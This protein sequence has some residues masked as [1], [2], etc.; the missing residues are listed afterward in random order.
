MYTVVYAHDY[1]DYCYSEPT[2]KLTV[3]KGDLILP[4]SFFENLNP[5]ATYTFGNEQD[6]QT[7]ETIYRYS[8][9]SQKALTLGFLN[10]YIK[11]EDNEGKDQLLL[12]LRCLKA[13]FQSAH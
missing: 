13:I 2:C 4:Q 11:A 6:L 1:M 5:R 12:Y 3:N 7:L 10:D 9:S 8:T